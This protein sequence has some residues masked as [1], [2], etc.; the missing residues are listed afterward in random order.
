MAV[1]GADNSPPDSSRRKKVR[2]PQTLLPEILTDRSPSCISLGF[3]FAPDQQ[4]WSSA[5][6]L[7]FH[8]MSKVQF[9]AWRIEEG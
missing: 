3:V 8:A 5:Q 2:E 4:C 6:V 9:E 7:S 1:T